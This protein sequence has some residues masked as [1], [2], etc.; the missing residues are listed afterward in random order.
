MVILPRHVSST[1]KLDS[2]TWAL[3][4]FY[5][6]VDLHV[7][8]FKVGLT[9]YPASAESFEPPAHIPPRQN[10]FISDQS[11]AL[12]LPM[13]CRRAFTQ[14]CAKM[15]TTCCIWWNKPKCIPIGRS[16]SSKASC[17]P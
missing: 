9:L 6:F 17:C 7:K 4:T 2:V 13:M 8:G 10:L 5:A 1:A 15:L 3:L 11:N 16:G 14:R 12:A